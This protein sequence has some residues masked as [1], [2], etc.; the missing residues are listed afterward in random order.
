MDVPN[1]ENSEQKPVVQEEPMT[2]I[3]QSMTQT[4]PTPKYPAIS[5]LISR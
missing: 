4:S 1:L 5:T 2:K 3:P